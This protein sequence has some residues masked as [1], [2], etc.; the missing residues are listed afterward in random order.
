MN[1]IDNLTGFLR[2]CNILYIIVKYY[3][4]VPVDPIWR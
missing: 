2:M 3:C 4:I 1:A